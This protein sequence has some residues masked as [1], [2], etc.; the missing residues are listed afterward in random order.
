[1]YQLKHSTNNSIEFKST[2]ESFTETTNEKFSKPSKKAEMENNKPKSNSDQNPE[3]M[4]EQ[5]SSE[6]NR[7]KKV[8]FKNKLFKTNSNKAYRVVLKK[9]KTGFG[10]AIS[11]DRSHRLIV[12]GLNPTGVA[13]QAGHI[14][15]GDEIMKVNGVDVK[16]MNYDDIMSMLHSTADPVEFYLRRLDVK[17]MTING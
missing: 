2:D 3:Q 8:S 6:V 10:I 17:G 12:R 15:I 9:N 1:M 13:Q 4:P 14:Q 16:T 7:D 5:K 11:E